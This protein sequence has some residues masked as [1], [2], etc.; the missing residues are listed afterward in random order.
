MPSRT[1]LPM[2]D[3]NSCSS[4]PPASS[5]LDVKRAEVWLA[6]NDGAACATERSQLQFSGVKTRVCLT[7]NIKSWHGFVFL[8]NIGVKTWFFPFT[9]HRGQD[10]GLSSPE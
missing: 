10:V 6:K 7:P 3:W 9:L 4:A 5:R 1:A 8:S 2:Q